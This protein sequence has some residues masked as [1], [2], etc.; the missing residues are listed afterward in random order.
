[1]QLKHLG[2]FIKK[3]DFY[4]DKTKN[5][6]NEIISKTITVKYITL[7]NLIIIKSINSI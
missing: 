5:R 7:R 3:L 4:Q 6:F 1:M 2:K